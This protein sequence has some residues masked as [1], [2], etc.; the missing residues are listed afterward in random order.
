LNAEAESLIW[1]F[2]LWHVVRARYISRHFLFHGRR[3][4]VPLPGSFDGNRHQLRTYT[5][6]LAF[7]A[8]ISERYW[9]AA[10]KARKVV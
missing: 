8:N 9:G 10:K 5:T 2:C 3:D 6:F 7:I 4:V 1:Q